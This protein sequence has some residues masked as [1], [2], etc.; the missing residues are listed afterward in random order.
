[1]KMKR[2]FHGSHGSSGGG[3]PVLDKQDIQNLPLPPKVHKSVAR[4]LCICGECVYFALLYSRF[5]LTC[6]FSS[7]VVVVVVLLLLLLLLFSGSG[8]L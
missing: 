6:C 7:L 2:K 3:V 1:M 5:S 4:M 8:S